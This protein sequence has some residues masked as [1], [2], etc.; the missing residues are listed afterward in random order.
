METLPDPLLGRIFAAA[1]QEAGVSAGGRVGV[2]VLVPAGAAA[3]R[4]RRSLGLHPPSLFP[5]ALQDVITLVS[6]RWHQVFYSEPELWHFLALT[7]ESL[8]TA[9][10]VGQTRQWFAAKALLLRRI[11][12]FVQHLR[13]SQL[14]VE[15]SHPDAYDGTLIDMQQLAADSGAEW[16]LGSSVLAHLSPATLQSLRLG[17]VLVDAGAAAALQ[18]LSSLT[19]LWIE[20]EDALPS[21][22]VVALASLPWLL[23]LELSACDIPLGLPTALQHLTQLTCLVLDSCSPLPELS[24]VFA[25]T[26][27]RRLGWQEMRQA[28]ALHVD[29][30]QLLAQLRQLQSLDIGSVQTEPTRGSLQV[31]VHS[32]AWHGES[33]QCIHWML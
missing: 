11:G 3:C 33:E 22:I 4:C 29:P 21:R 20:C 24:A 19:Q 27:L 5:R 15:D 2:W 28:G 26:Q 8:D 7:V 23:S 32:A 1:A 12:G 25:L 18:R 13:C 6:R 16:Q 30:Q 31:R 9:R 14:L 17:W 10:E